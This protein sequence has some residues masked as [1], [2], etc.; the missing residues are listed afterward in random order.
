MTITYEGATEQTRQIIHHHAML[1]RGR[2]RRAG[3]LCEAVQSGVPFEPQ[4]TTL[5]DYLAGEILPHA[6]AEERTL[7]PAAVT[8]ARGS[9]LVRALTAEHHALAYLAG[10]LQPGADGSEA[11]TAAERIASLFAGHVAK[12]NDLLLPAL[13]GAGADLAALLA[14]MHRP[15]AAAPT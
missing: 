3:T 2:E 10:R 6:Q 13:T 8:Q 4:M 15:Q 14:E 1:R 9:E 7:Y 12:E 11:A 5:R